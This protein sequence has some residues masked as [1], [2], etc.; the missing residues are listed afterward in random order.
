MVWT[1][2]H[3]TK[4]EMETAPTTTNRN[5]GRRSRVHLHTWPL[6]LIFHNIHNRQEFQ[7]NDR[8]RRADCKH[9]L[10]S[11]E[12]QALVRIRIYLDYCTFPVDSF[13]VVL[14]R[15]SLRD[16]FF[17]RL[18]IDNRLFDLVGSKILNTD[19]LRDIY[20]GSNRNN[21]AGNGTSK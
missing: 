13:Q 4:S 6:E 17:G 7:K 1:S 20:L 8:C 9:P 21:K 18:L 2:R 16:I 11:E 15:L 10:N 12:D 3:R 5:L 14:M 19:F